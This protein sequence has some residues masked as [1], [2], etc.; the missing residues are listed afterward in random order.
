MS[1]L[2]SRVRR[3]SLAPYRHLP[4]DAIV[5]TAPQVELPR[6]TEPRPRKLTPEHV[7]GVASAVAAGRTL[8]DVAADF[9][10][11]PERVRQVAR[12]QAR[13]PLAAD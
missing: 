6:Y 7:E 1:R 2:R 11:S 4:E 10:I 3:G 5:L 8:R 13:L 9:G 12:E